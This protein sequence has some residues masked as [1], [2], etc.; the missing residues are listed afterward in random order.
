VV[1][2]WRCKALFPQ[3]LIE[4]RALKVQIKFVDSAVN[5]ASC[6]TSCML[7]VVTLNWN[8]LIGRPQSSVALH[9][10]AGGPTVGLDV[11]RR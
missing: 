8:I 10:C 3:C 9:L 7:S 4:H 1:G 5:D 2:A 6:T 11:L